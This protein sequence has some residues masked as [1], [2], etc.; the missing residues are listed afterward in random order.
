M[1]PR[2]RAPCLL[3]GDR[4]GREFARYARSRGFSQMKIVANN[5]RPRE[6]C[7]VSSTGE[8]ELRRN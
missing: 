5:L 6:P 8:A 2:W 7:N 4:S 3:L 1:I